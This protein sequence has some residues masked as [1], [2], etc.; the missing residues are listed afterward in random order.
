MA[1]VVAS[2]VDVITSSALADVIAMVV[3]V[4]TTQGDW[5]YGRC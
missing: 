3:D 4:K 5:C 2:V 1:D